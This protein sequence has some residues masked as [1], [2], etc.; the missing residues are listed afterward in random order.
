M[1]RNIRWLGLG[2]VVRAGGMTLVAPY[3][4]LYL[5]NVLQIGYAEIGLLTALTGVIPLLVVPFAGFVTDRI[6][7]RRVFLVCLVAEALCVLLVAEAMNVR[8]L[9]GLL[10]AA[11][12]VYTVGT[13]AGPAISAYVADFAEGSERTL[14]FTYTRIGWN[15]GFTLGVLAGGALIGLIGFPD[16]GFLAGG[17]LLVATALLAAVLRPSPYDLARGAARRLP[18]GDR[19]PRASLSASARVLGRDRVFLGLCA[20]VGLAWLT[21]GQWGTIFPLYANTVLHIPYDLIG[22]GLA[23]NGLLVVF[24]QAP[25][26]RA[27]FG[28][29]HTSLFL[30]GT[31]LYAAGFLLLGGFAALRFEV[32]LG[33]FLAIVV[34]TTGENLTSIPTTT[35]PSNL[36]PPDEIGAYN[37]AYF[38]I[39]GVG[40]LLAPTLGG[41]VLALTANPLLTWA[42][43]VGPSLPAILWLGGFVAPRIAPHANR[44]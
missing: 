12:A 38:A 11:T 21:I 40:Q 2:G 8:W 4:V 19:P 10:A 22:V 13:V 37:G 43:L 20:S 3:L 7:R 14:A 35:L 30:A 1:D 27:G 42:I 33:F 6:G 16:V 44:A 26:T 9:P 18:V 32:L 36:A 39:T 34:L 17:T 28:H 25:I 5:R 29:R 31:A 24:T 41:L 23:I 15:V